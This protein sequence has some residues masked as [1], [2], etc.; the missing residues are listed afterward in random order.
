MYFYWM[1][2]KLQDTHVFLLDVLCLLCLYWVSW[3]FSLE[4]L[5]DFFSDSRIVCTVRPSA[6]LGMQQ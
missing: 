2:C 1:S 6:P 3:N 5:W 4:L